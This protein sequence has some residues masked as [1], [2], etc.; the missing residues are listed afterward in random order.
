MGSAGA[1]GGRWI[2]LKDKHL[3]VCQPANGPCDYSAED[4]TAASASLWQTPSSR[5]HARA[6][7][8]NLRLIHDK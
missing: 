4:W 1:K 6:V 8:S 3:G 5:A 7:R 2:A